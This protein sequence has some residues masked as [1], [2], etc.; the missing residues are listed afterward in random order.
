MTFLSLGI[1]LSIFGIFSSL[2]HHLKERRQAP[3]TSL[4]PPLSATVLTKQVL[5]F[6]NKQQSSY[7]G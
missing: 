7:L 6:Q 2:Y 3:L 5:S 4:N 1:F